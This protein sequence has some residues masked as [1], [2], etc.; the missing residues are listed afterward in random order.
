[1][2]LQDSQTL[3]DVGLCHGSQMMAFLVRS[4]VDVRKDFKKAFKN[5]DVDH[6]QILRVE[7]AQ[8][9]IDDDELADLVNEPIVWGVETPAYIAAREGASEVLR[10]LVEIRAD[11]DQIRHSVAPAHGAALV[12]NVDGLATLKDLS[13]N[14]LH[15]PPGGRSWR[16]T[17]LHLAAANGHVDAVTFLK[18][19]GADNA[20]SGC[21]AVQ[22]AYFGRHVSCVQV[23]QPALVDRKLLRGF[24][25]P[26]SSGSTETK[27]TASPRPPT[28]RIQ[29][30]SADFVD[31]ASPLDLR[32]RA[33]SR[34]ISAQQHARRQASIIAGQGPVV[35]RNEENYCVLGKSVRCKMTKTKPIRFVDLEE[36][37][38]FYDLVECDVIF[39]M[40]G[41][42]D[43]WSHA[44]CDDWSDDWSDD[45]SSDDDVIDDDT[46]IQLQTGFF[47][48]CSQHELQQFQQDSL[49]LVQMSNDLA[50][51]DHEMDSDDHEMDS[52]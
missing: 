11:V 33:Y 4:A 31:F 27:M 38:A 43:S 49:E 18:E 8:S 22:L 16:T 34:R 45:N 17:P 13:A 36:D 52:D 25:R 50:K 47:R 12:G 23:L 46:I 9:G 5:L 42:G 2:H 24:K 29:S 39:D 44:C 30:V 40:Y 28:Q 32:E 14:L 1:M 26:S 35:C 20:P 37:I 7:A 6:I 51:Y 3:L 41:E 15:N 19:C 10:L 21:N 48:A